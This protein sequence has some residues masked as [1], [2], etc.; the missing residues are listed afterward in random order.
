MCVCGWGL[1]DGPRP[2]VTCDIAFKK[3]VTCDM[4]IS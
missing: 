3:I 4:I 2:L 1:C